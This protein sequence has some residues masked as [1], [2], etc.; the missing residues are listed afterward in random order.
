MEPNTSETKPA[1][2]RHRNRQAAWL[3]KK[4]AGKRE[5]LL[6]LRVERNWNKETRSFQVCETS[7]EAEE[8]PSSNAIAITAVYEQIFI[9][10]IKT[11]LDLEYFGCFR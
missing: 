6:T 4:R 5:T 9:R 1:G 11:G 2:L 3:L 8:K 10:K 7:Q